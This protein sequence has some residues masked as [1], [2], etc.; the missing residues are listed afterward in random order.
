M[1]CSNWST[2]G[3]QERDREGQRGRGGRDRGREVR[4]DREGGE[5]GIEVGR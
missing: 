2:A 1:L 4:R 5:G 3:I